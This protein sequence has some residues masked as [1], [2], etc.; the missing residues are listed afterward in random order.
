MT[1]TEIY[2]LKNLTKRQQWVL[3]NSTPTALHEAQIKFWAGE[4]AGRPVKEIEAEFELAC[5][6]AGI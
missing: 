1:R 4:A 3:I 2:N 5:K 6:A